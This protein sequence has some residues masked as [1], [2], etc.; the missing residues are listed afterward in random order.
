M[1]FFFFFWGL[2]FIHLFIFNFTGDKLCLLLVGGIDGGWIS[3]KKW[4]V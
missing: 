4:T 2:Y 1:S 3:R